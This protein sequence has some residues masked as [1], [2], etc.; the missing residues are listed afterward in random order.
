M[1]IYHGYKTIKTIRYTII[2]MLIIVISSPL[3]AAD[4]GY[5][6]KAVKGPLA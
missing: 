3:S 1:K 5:T 2:L 6:V 4:T